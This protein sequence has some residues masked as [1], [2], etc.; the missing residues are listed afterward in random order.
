MQDGFVVFQAASKTD[1]IS[2]NKY[3]TTTAATIT[4]ITTTTVSLNITNR[5]IQEALPQFAI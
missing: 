5:N 4:I 1:D 3:Y 2:M